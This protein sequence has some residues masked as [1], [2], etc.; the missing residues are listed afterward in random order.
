DELVTTSERPLDYPLGIYQP[1]YGQT[2]PAT[3]NPHTNTREVQ[4]STGLF[5]Q[6]QISLSSDWRLLLGLRHENFRKQFENRRTG[7]RISQEDDVTTPRIGL[8]WLV[9]PNVSLYA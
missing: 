5:V 4:R 6:D 7:V 1:V 3:S 8:T 2:L 9:S